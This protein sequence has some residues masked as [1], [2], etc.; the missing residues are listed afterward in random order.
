M[1]FKLRDYQTDAVNSAINWIKKTTEPCLIEL[2]TGAGKSLV[3]AELAKILT[4]ISKG[5]KVLVLQPSLELLTQNSAK[6]KLTGEHCSLFSASAGVKSLRHSVVYATPLTVK[7]ALSK[8]D[9]KFCAVILD[10]SHLLTPTII[11]IIDAIKDHNK[12]LRVIG[13]TASPY[14]MTNGL[15]YKLDNN[16]KPTPEDKAKNPYFTKL[17]YKLSARY[18]IDQGYLTN[19]VIGST[20][21]RY[22]TN[23]LEV[24]SG[25]YTQESIDR[26]FVGFNRKTSR[27]VEEIV[28]KSREHKT[29]MIFGATIAHCDEIM[30]SLPPRISRMIDGNTPKKEREQI[31]KD[32]KEL[33]IKYLVSCET[34]TT[35]I[36]IESVS[37]IAI[38][39]ATLSPVLITQI[40]GRALRVYPGKKEAI[41]LDYTSTN[42]DYFFPDGDLFS[43]QIRASKGKSSDTT[44]TAKC[45]L[46]ETENEFSARPNEDG[47]DIDAYGYYTDLNGIRIMTE[48]GPM[49][50]HYG[51]R[52]M[53]LHRKSDGSFKPCAYYWT[54]KE[55]P[56][57]GVKA[58]IAARYC[59]NK[60]EL[61]DPNE[62]LIIEYRKMRKDPHIK[63]TEHVL[64]WSQKKTLSSKGNECLQVNYVTEHRNIMIWYQPKGDS[65]YLLNEYNRFISNTKGGDEMP[66]SLTYQKQPNG[67]YRIFNYNETVPEAP[68]I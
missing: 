20:G 45:E 17:V 16:D 24:K 37:I 8:F 48:Y 10:E 47:F 50:A 44:I 6:F 12:N 3:I 66:I 19:P 14:T 35:G 63:Q 53:A 41:I 22:D 11:K 42:I 56:E 27:I 18:L 5:K 26:A 38:L 31:I 59:S 1:Q 36:D 40:I 34:L 29:V 62:R 64:S 43:P 4:S 55:C 60:H 25:K 49:S 30:A 33:K 2:P 7:G 61:I 52:C 67:F 51:R 57:C 13:L 68:V 23:N 28:L 46:C 58:D 65:Q 39:R 9:D 54:S 21:D 32:T 15:L